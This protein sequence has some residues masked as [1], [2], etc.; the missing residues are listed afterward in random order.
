M[1]DPGYCPHGTYILV[2][3]QDNSEEY[4]AYTS[5]EFMSRN[6]DERDASSQLHGSGK[7]SQ[8]PKGCIGR[9]KEVEECTWQE[10]EFPIFII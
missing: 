6:M 10:I 1:P 9:V 8:R 7:V 4:D 3:N 2:G 5:V